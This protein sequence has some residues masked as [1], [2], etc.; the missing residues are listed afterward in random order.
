[1]Q[2]F[3]QNHLRNGEKYRV[4]DVG[5]YGVNGTYKEIF[6]SQPFE[7]VGL[8]MQAGPNVDIV[9]A[10]PYIWKEIASDSFDVVIS[11]QAFE[12]IE[13]FWLTMKE[14]ARVVRPGGLICIIAPRG[15]GFHRYPVDCYRFDVD[16]MV[17][18]ARYCNLKPLHASTNRAPSHSLRVVFVHKSRLYSCRPKAREL[19]RHAGY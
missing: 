7:Y 2:W 15:F 9:P 18:L 6:A 17:A 19:E 1:M 10:N 4:L 13:F 16:G 12:H 5:S 8:D 3:V 11:G 14:I